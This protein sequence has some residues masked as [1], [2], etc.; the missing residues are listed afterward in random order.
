MFFVVK[1]IM[2]KIYEIYF[3][4]IK[5]LEGSEVE[6]KENLLKIRRYKVNVYILKVKKKKF[7]C[8]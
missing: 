2:F 5:I 3:I 8:I 7:L 1:I 6:K 4:Y